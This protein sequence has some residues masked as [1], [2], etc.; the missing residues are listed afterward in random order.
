MID[1]TINV[2]PSVVLLPKKN[3][4]ETIR[5]APIINLMYLSVEPTFFAI[6][7]H[8]FVYTIVVYTLVVYTTYLSLLVGVKILYKNSS[9]LNKNSDLFKISINLMNYLIRLHILNNTE[10]FNKLI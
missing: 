1:N 9:T 6:I 8:L 5:I 7:V 3:I 10:V 2:I 4:P